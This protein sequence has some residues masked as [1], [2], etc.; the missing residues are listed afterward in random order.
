MFEAL[1]RRVRLASLG[2]AQARVAA[3]TALTPCYGR[4]TVRSCY[5]GYTLAIHL[6]SSMWGCMGIVE[7]GVEP[8]DGGASVVEGGDEAVCGAVGGAPRDD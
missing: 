2:V 1:D 8:S 3:Q 4:E 5:A 6:G 7:I